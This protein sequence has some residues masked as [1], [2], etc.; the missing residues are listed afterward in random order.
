[1]ST[2][3]IKGKNDNFNGKITFAKNLIKQE[4]YKNDLPWV[5]GYS[6]G[7]DSTFLVDLIISSILEL[8]KNQLNKKIYILSS[9]TLVENP[10]VIESLSNSINNINDFAKI[11]NLPLIA[12]LVRPKIE[13]SFW[14]NLIGRGYPAP[15]QTFRWC[16]SR[17]K[18]DSMSNYVGEKISKDKKVIYVIGVRQGESG[19]RDKVLEKYNNMSNDRYVNKHNTDVNAFVFKPIIDFDTKEV[20]E[21]LLSKPNTHWKVSTGNLYELYRDSSNECPLALD[22]IGTKKVNSSCG[23]SRW[24][25]WTCTVAKEDRSITNLINNGYKELEPLRDFRN[26]LQDERDKFENRYLGS[27][28]I[29]KST[30]KI[31]LVKNRTMRLKYK[32]KDTKKILFIPKKNTR[33]SKNWEILKNGWAVSD[34]GKYKIISKDKFINLIQTNKINMWNEIGNP[35]A[36]KIIIHFKDNDYR[37]PGIGPYNLRYRKE[38]YDKLTKLNDNN[39]FQNLILEEEREIIFSIWNNIENNLTNCTR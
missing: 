19:A 5:I 7:K 35:F 33:P 17:L 36:T 14:V 23:N 30:K 10:L 21:Y 9:D 39:N 22:Q 11:N 29:N 16:T 15:N 34:D 4:Y 24:G 25:C 8:D 37:I 26:W 31:T 3:S 28:R 20:W 1:M 12:A 6:G 18:I 27:I 32:E 2:T 38:I 13:E